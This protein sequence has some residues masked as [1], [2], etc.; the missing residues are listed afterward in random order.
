MNQ[1]ELE[2]YQNRDEGYPEC[3]KETD[4]SLK[5]R[6]ILD[7]DG[8]CSDMEPDLVDIYR[9]SGFLYG[10]DT[11]EGYRVCQRANDDKYHWFLDY[12]YATPI[13]NKKVVIFLGKD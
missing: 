9:R 6:L 11:G 5:L 12:Q 10:Y 7:E 3:T 1:I 8:G 4:H 2:D 13:K